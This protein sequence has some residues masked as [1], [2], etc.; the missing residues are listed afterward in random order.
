MKSSLSK[1]KFN[2]DK[3][4]I[5]LIIGICIVTNNQLF[6]QTPEMISSAKKGDPKAQFLLSKAYLTGEKTE[7]SSTNAYK[8]ATASA[9]QGYCPSQFL[10]GYQYFQGLGTKKDYGKAAE[11]FS[12]SIK[13]PINCMNAQLQAMYYLSIMTSSGLGVKKDE[14]LAVSL[15][16]QG[17]DKNYPKAQ[18]LL[19]MYYEEGIGVPQEF[20]KAI[21]YYKKAAEQGYHP[22]QTSLATMYLNQKGVRFNK[23]EVM[24]WY[25]L[26]ADQGNA[27][28]QRNLGLIYE[29][30]FEDD[31]KIDMKK[32]R[33]WYSQA[34]KNGDSE[35][36]IWMGDNRLKNRKYDEAKDW[37][38]KAA[39]LGSADAM[40]RLGE[41]YYSPFISGFEEDLSKSIAWHQLAAER[42][43]PQS[44]IRMGDYYLFGL[45]VEEDEK[46]A[47]EYYL[48]AYQQGYSPTDPSLKK[49]SQSTDPEIASTGR[50]LL[51]ESESFSASYAKSAFSSQSKNLTRDEE[52]VITGVLLLSGLLVLADQLS[53]SGQ[54]G[55]QTKSM[56]E[57]SMENQARWREQ[58]IETLK[59]IGTSSSSY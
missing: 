25:T 51:A 35:A 34:A 50:N 48:R 46:K 41:M 42:N 15:A 8:W 1:I 49:L 40:Q 55:S 28:A 4:S 22:A 24:K 13:N 20:N 33:Y 7:Q 5:A 12:K 29:Y 31:P 3:M 44:L 59:E 17:A 23:A 56:S 37:Y 39:Y 16:E 30:G 27:V 53:P 18:H 54:Y 6:A 47:L 10:L 9:M 43:Q 26:A 21:S 58:H 14:S 52:S 45:G 36:M 38:E 32:A 11:W 57:I 19:G 2:F